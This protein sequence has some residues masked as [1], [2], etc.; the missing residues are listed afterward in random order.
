MAIFAFAVLQRGRL[1]VTRIIDLLN[2]GQRGLFKSFNSAFKLWT[3]KLPSICLLQA[4][5]SFGSIK[6]IAWQRTGTRR[7]E[8]V[9]TTRF[10]SVLISFPC[11]EI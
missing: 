11:G 10:K 8:D 2:I 3:V 6:K 4:N 9:L 5:I 1:V 7:N